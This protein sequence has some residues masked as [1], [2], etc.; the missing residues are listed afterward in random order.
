MSIG[1]LARRLLA[2]LR[3]TPLH[4]QWLL[5]NRRDIRRRLRALPPGRILDL[6]CADRWVEQALPPG[7]DYL[8]L[9]HYGTG[10]LMYGARPDA[11]ADAIAL[12]LT[13]ASVDAVVLLEVLE[14]L[15]APDQ[16][17]A[18]IARVLRPG[19]RLLLTMPFLY[20]L[21]DA[22]HDFQRYTTHGLEA[23]L[24]RARLRVDAVEPGL[25]SLESAGLLGCLA[26][27]GSTLAAWNRR[28]PAVLLAPLVLAA[29]PLVNLGAWLLGRLMPTWPALTAGHT[30]LATRP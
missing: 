22:P 5:G 18:E 16:A 23:A 6:G 12:P 8:G 7:C 17:L 3:R 2:P 14:H 30:V 1:G 13:D 4:P 15:P 10:R 20:P 28:S 24:A 27:V 29:I 11:Y 21:H 19:G 26:L 9:D 25:G